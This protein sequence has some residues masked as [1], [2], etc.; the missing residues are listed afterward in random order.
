M[1]GLDD[2][3]T[4]DDA[5]LYLQFRMAAGAAMFPIAIQPPPATEQFRNIATGIVGA[6]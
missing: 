6:S 1:T 5:T 2:G 3:T 4:R